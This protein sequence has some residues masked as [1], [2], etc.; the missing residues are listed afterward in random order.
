MRVA[1]VGGTGYSGAELV[2]LLIVHPELEE[3][4][5]ASRSRAGKTVAL[6]FPALPTPPGLVFWAP[7]DPALLVGLDAI[8]FATP[9]GVA[10][11]LA[12]AALDAGVIVVDLSADFR[13]SDAAL[14]RQWYGMQHSSQQ[15]LS[16]VVWGLP[17]LTRE[18]LRGAR[19]I[20]CPGCYT[21]AVLLGLMPAVRAGVVNPKMLVA[22]CKSGL[23]G[24]GREPK[25]S[26]LF[27]EVGENI[28]AYAVAGHRHQPEMEQALHEFGQ[29]DCG[30]VFTPHLIPV[31]RGMMATLHLQV[32]GSHNLRECYSEAYANEPF[33][34]LEA[35]G[36]EPQTR[37]VR[38]TNTCRLGLF[39]PQPD[40]VVVVSVIDNLTKGAA[41]QAVQ[42]CNL[43][44]GIPETAGLEQLVPLAV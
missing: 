13:L 20:S 41:G 16:E 40:R 18:R 32:T 17:E 5:I 31:V 27:S 8:F 6:E 39:Q 35:E 42:A 44:L 22:D 29:V 28:S 38:G 26:S 43:T 10:M 33:V 4:R 34:V 9:S 7:D 37:W 12:P 21:T 1:V 2:R 23:S 11:D 25:L 36:V 30:L 15:L 19:L 14:W 3:L 24:A